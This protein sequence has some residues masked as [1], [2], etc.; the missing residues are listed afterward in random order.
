[1]KT[2]RTR[3]VLA[4]LL[5]VALPAIAAEN[6]QITITPDSPA[7]VPTGLVAE[8]GDRFLIQAEG[9]MRFTLNLPFQGGWFDPSGLGRYERAGQVFPDSPWGVLSGTFRSSL[10]DG[11]TLGELASFDAQPVDQGYE[12][13]LGLNIASDETGLVGGAFV[14]SVTRYSADEADEAT[15]II[16]PDSPRPLGTGITATGTSD[17]IL[18]I[19]QG[20]ARVINRPVT[21]GWFDASGLGRFSSNGQI[22]ADTPYGALLGTFSNLNS[23]FYVGDVASWN[24]QPGDLDD[25]FKVYLNMEADDQA[26]MSGQI[27]AHV[28]RIR[29]VAVSAAPGGDVPARDAILAV[30]SYPNPFNPMTTVRFELASQQRARVAIVNVAGEVVR[31]LAHNTFTAGQHELAWDGRDDS[32]RSLASGTYL[33]RLQ[34]DQEVQTRKLALVR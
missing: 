10:T 27:V 34:T 1:M 15:V 23:G 24:A 28:L 8:S 11:F 3:L 31:T 18:V 12:L 17:K 14:V 26:S 32:G 13:Q 29:D 22:F 30:D 19:G 2:T 9:A 4:G 33:L 25:E 6:V 20:A 5:L 7:L 21:G 16:G